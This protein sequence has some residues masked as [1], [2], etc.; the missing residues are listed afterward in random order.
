MGRPDTYLQ[1]A[2]ITRAI[3]SAQDILKASKNTEKKTLKISSDCTGW[4]F[5]RFWTVDIPVDVPLP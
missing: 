4:R 2:E 5:N 1:D 3:K